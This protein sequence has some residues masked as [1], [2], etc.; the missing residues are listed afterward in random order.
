MPRRKN[1]ANADGSH[2]SRDQGK[3]DGDD[4]AKSLRAQVSGDF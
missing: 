2:R 4:L 1:R 3:R